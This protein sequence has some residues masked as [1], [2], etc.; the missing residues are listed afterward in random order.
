M[1]LFK[2]QM[3]TKWELDGIK[4]VFSVGL[5]QVMKIIIMV[6]VKYNNPYTD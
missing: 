3:Y 1:Y 6:L 4:Q 2:L 5:F